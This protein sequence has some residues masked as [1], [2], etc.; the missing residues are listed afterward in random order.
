MQRGDRM[1]DEPAHTP[2]FEE[3]LALGAQ[4]VSFAGWAMPQEYT[5]AEEEHR[6]VRSS[7][8]VFDLSHLGMVRVFG[9]GAFDYLQRLL[10]NDLAQIAELGAA[11]RTLMCDED[12]GII[13][14]LTVYHSGDLEYLIVT[15]AATRLTDMDWMERHRPAEADLVELVDESERT[16][17]IGLQGPVALDVFREL[18]AASTPR[19]HDPVPERSSLGEAR[20]DSVPALVARTSDTGEDGVQLVCHVST[21]PTL[22]RAI[23]SFAEVTPVGLAALDVLS[24]E[25][26]YRLYGRDIDRGVDPISAALGDLVCTEKGDFIGREAIERVRRHGPER[27]LVGLTAEEGAPQSGYSVLHEGSEVGK[28]ASGTFS[29]VRS[30]GIATAYVP[31]QY[32][33]PGTTLEIGMPHATVSTTVERMPFIEGTSLRD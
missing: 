17:L 14:E 4:M 23:L 21:A 30:R 7:A 1:A 9:F 11:Q 3:H 28:V 19:G 2:L 22:W 16:A 24:L 5:S 6:A 31:Y 13:D 33:E 18:A 10:T 27:L 29:P 26:G 32:S 15:N 20:L 12:G 8:G 25:M